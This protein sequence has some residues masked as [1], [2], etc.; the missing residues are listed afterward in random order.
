MKGCGTCDLCSDGLELVFVQGPKRKKMVCG[1]V[2]CVPGRGLRTVL[3]QSV[4]AFDFRQLDDL[5]ES[6][7]VADC[8]L[9]SACGVSG[10]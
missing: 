9:V 10:V 8:I 4:G 5:R 1:V 2:G 7:A 3:V 6:L